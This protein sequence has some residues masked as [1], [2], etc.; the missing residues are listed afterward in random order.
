MGARHVDGSPMRVLIYPGAIDA[1]TTDA[2]DHTDEVTRAGFIR[3][4]SSAV[5]GWESQFTIQAKDTGR[6]NRY[7][8]G[9][10]IFEI[11]LTGTNGWSKFGRTNAVWSG[12]IIP[13]DGQPITLTWSGGHGGLLS[14]KTTLCESCVEIYQGS[15]VINLTH[16]LSTG[17]LS[18][19]DIVTLPL[20][21]GRMLRRP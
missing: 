6:N 18:R 5:A 15:R 16:S 1:A 17:E 13:Q 4:L 2:S 10:D 3:G 7:N 12:G 20:I 14:W 9:A 21:E 8:N 19:G 11:K